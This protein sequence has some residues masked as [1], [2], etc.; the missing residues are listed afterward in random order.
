MCKIYLYNNKYM[1][2]KPLYLIFFIFSAFEIC[3]NGLDNSEYNTKQITLECQ[4]GE[5][6][7]EYIDNYQFNLPYQ[8]ITQ[9]SGYAS[10]KNLKK[11]T[12]N[13]YEADYYDDEIKE[14]G[15]FI[16]NDYLVI[17]KFEW[18]GDGRTV[19]TGYVQVF[20]LK[21]GERYFVNDYNL[22]YFK[23]EPEYKNNFLD[24]RWK[25][26]SEFKGKCA[27]KIEKPIFNAKEYE[28]IKITNIYNKISPLHKTWIQKNILKNKDFKIKVP[29]YQN[30]HDGKIVYGEMVKYSD[31]KQRIEDIFIEYIQESLSKSNY[32]PAPSIK[33]YG[34]ISM[35]QKVSYMFE[36]MITDYKK[37]LYSKFSYPKPPNSSNFINKDAIILQCINFIT[38]MENTY[39]ENMQTY[40]KPSSGRASMASKI[41]LMNYFYA[42]GIR[43][44]D[45]NENLKL[46]NYQYSD[47]RF[48]GQGFDPK[49]IGINEIYTSEES[50]KDYCNKLSNQV[51]IFAGREIIIN[52]DDDEIKETYFILET[53]E[54]EKK[55]LS[56]VHLTGK[57]IV[58]Y[59][60][61]T[62]NEVAPDGLPYGNYEL[63]HKIKDELITPFVVFKWSD[64]KNVT[65][66]NRCSVYFTGYGVG[67]RQPVFFGNNFNNKM[68]DRISIYKSSLFRQS[69]TWMFTSDNY[70]ISN[71]RTSLFF[72]GNFANRKDLRNIE[73]FYKPF[74]DTFDW[75]G[76][77]SMADEKSRT[78]NPLSIGH[79]EIGQPVNRINNEI[80]N[81]EQC[82]SALQSARESLISDINSG[83][84]AKQTN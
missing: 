47:G 52:Y 67:H 30:F 54:I 24:D 57:G 28:K 39:I 27:L 32:S 49:V 72:F 44:A 46:L 65:P 70:K 42:A 55:R 80:I 60:R 3:A 25:S 16:V 17:D 61:T 69:V 13:A 26:I 20:D 78:S 22:K 41:D 63:L 34:P 31:K 21:T 37:E 36:Q 9:I 1:P 81:S 45:I 74:E 23:N 10:Q 58:E 40:K 66:R 48:S 29:K 77:L 6:A 14:A 51:E 68:N 50:K 18:V 64:K 79:I 82:K 73:N 11:I 53:N 15:F 62:V 5:G 76:F 84:L 83:W 71:D 56:G 38:I 19:G 4:S 35:D 2:V 43:Y 33:F 12:V 75:D 59:G 7:N 8:K